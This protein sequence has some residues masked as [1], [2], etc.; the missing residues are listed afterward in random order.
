MAYTKVDLSALPAPQILEHISYEDILSRLKAAVSAVFPALSPVLQL[1]SEPAVKVLQVCAAYIMLARARVNDGAKSML[2]AYAAGTDLDHIGAMFGVERKI[3]TPAT[4]TTPA[5]LETDAELRN[6]IQLSLEGAST[7]G[8]RGAY[9]FH[10]LSAHSDVRDVFVASPGTPGLTIAPGSVG[11][12]VLSRAGDGVPSAEVLADVTAALNADDVRPLCD[13]VIVAGAT[14][15]PYAVVA[16]LHVPSGPGSEV[17]LAAAQ[18]A[19]DEY[20]MSV[21]RIGA[22]VA[23]SGIHAALH[24]A[25]VISVTVTSPPGDIVPAPN[26]A[27]YATS[28]TVTLAE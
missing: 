9:E 6:R 28:A 4:D 10:A 21:H 23:M 24:Q 19:L 11:V 18:A 25:G 17:I 14:I 22:T 7:A 26:V 27:P 8:P 3:I 12:Y 13:T 2:L 1:E 15:S 20:L 16:E 5:V